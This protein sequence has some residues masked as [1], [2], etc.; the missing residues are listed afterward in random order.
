MTKIIVLKNESFALLWFFFVTNLFKYQSDIRYFALAE[1]VIAENFF[2]NEFMVL[3]AWSPVF[4]Q[5]FSLF[6]VCVGGSF[7]KRMRYFN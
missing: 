4:C 2:S 5:K 1:G 7:C 3:L 6:L